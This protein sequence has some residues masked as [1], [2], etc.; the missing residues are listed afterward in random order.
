MSDNTE[1]AKEVLNIAVNKTVEV[2]KV[3]ADKTE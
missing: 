2:G 1:K 3:V